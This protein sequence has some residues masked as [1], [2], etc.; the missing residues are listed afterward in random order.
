MCYVL[1]RKKV[2]R[3]AK[4]VND[5]FENK[6]LLYHK[7]SKRCVET[8]CREACFLVYMKLFIDFVSLQILVIDER[9]RRGGSGRR[10]ER[11][12][13][14][15]RHTLGNDMLHYGGHGGSL[16]RS[17]DLEVKNRNSRRTS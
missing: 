9:N 11:E 16:Q 8:I 1:R 10:D 13:D 14:I 7:V 2:E 5:N 12:K 15:R 3:K 6:K 17:M 4:S